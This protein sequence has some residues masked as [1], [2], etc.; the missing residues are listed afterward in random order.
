MPWP[1]GMAPIAPSCQKGPGAGEWSWMSQFAL[2]MDCQTPFRLGLPSGIRLL[3]AEVLALALAA[4]AC[5]RA[6]WGLAKRATQTAA[7]AAVEKR[8][9]DLRIERNSHGAHL[10]CRDS[11]SYIRATLVSI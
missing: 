5:A 4:G 6:W 7:A 10:R 9:K 2:E 3:L 1:A 11:V 8:V